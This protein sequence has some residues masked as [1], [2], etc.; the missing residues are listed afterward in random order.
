[1]ENRTEGEN[2]EA[3]IISQDETHYKIYLGLACGA[4]FL[5]LLKSLT[6]VFIVYRFES[7]MF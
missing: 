1:M 3:E 6:F 2:K 4:M 5:I 7:E